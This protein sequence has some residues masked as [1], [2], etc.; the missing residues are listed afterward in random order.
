MEYDLG[1]EG[2]LIIWGVEEEGR[3]VEGMSVVVGRV[4]DRVE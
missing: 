4:T 2:V 1:D 3:Y